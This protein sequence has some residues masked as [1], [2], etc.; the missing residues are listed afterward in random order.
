MPPWR[1]RAPRGATG[2]VV[3]MDRRT[4]Q[5]TLLLAAFSLASLL[6]RRALADA[7]NAGSQCTPNGTACTYVS[8]GYAN[9]TVGVCVNGACTY[10]KAAA[11]NAACLGLRAQEQPACS[12][13]VIQAT[14]AASE[15]E[16]AV[17]REKAE[18]T[19][20][21]NQLILETDTADCP[22][23]VALGTNHCGQ[24]WVQG[25]SDA[26]LDGA[27]ALVQSQVDRVAAILTDLG[28]P[29]D[30]QN[31][32]QPTVTAAL[33]AK[34]KSCRAT[35]QCMIA[36]QAKA[37]R[38]EICALVA[39]IQNMRERIRI[40]RANPSGVVDLVELHDDG[41]IIQ[42]DQAALASK[43]AEYLKLTGKA[44]PETQCK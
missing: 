40:E 5:A 13:V 33:V 16:L 9:G 21:L 24:H 27:V 12:R 39:E 6:V 41:E 38:E 14:V 31:V 36:R 4:T 19:T 7:P 11:C 8:K 20:L 42:N 3:P 28:Q 18:A 1:D 34:E 2:R 15:R 30:P 17:Q 32:S 10:C 22:P 25:L 44:F 37:L 26:D 43:K 29:P 23:G 35:P